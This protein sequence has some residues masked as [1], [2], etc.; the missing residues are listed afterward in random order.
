MVLEKNA[1]GG[2]D[3]ASANKSDFHVF[4]L[5]VVFGYD[6]KEQRNTDHANLR[7]SK[8]R[9]VESPILTNVK[10][11]PI[12]SMGD[13]TKPEGGCLILGK[14]K[15]SSALKINNCKK[16]DH[17]IIKMQKWMVLFSLYHQGLE[18]VFKFTSVFMR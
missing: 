9:V 13:S 8:I 16:T 15:R 1:Q 4:H 14:E 7:L 2:A 18:Q 17:Y 11:R 3:F 6:R 10:L 5:F 12:V